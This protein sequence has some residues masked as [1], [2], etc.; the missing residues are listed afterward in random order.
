MRRLLGAPVVPL[1]AAP[2]IAAGVVAGGSVAGSDAVAS[3]GATVGSVSL[4][5]IHVS[6]GSALVV[7]SA[8]ILCRVAA[9][10]ESVL[11]IR[12]SRILGS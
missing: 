6:F 5:V 4:D 8:S 12:V 11:R 2:G 3:P 9:V 7:E 1:N 10:H